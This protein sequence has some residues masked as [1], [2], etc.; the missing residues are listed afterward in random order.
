MNRM[1]FYGICFFIAMG[2]ASAQTA[3]RPSNKDVKRIIE[4][5]EKERARFQDALD[6]QLKNG[7]F[8]NANGEIHVMQYL[9]DF[10]KNIKTLKER[11]TNSYSASS[12]VKTVLVQAGYIDELVQNHPGAGG[13]S[14]WAHFSVELR[15]LAAAY[16]ASFPLPEGVV[17]RRYIDAEVSSTAD[18]V[19]K[20]ADDLKKE[21]EINATLSREAKDSYKRELDLLI[22]QAN[23][24]KWRTFHSDPAASEARK[25]LEQARRI[26][27]SLP[28]ENTS[29]AITASWNQMEPSLEI[30]A[31]AFG[32]PVP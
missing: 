21:I 31:A 3:E 25:L 7:V 24:V 32:M 5:L 29:G 15:A 12:E 11:Y 17:V 19:A 16:G 13:G 14:E 8:H 2:F 18:T 9:E 26:H 22:K 28:K 6:E 20:K 30:I 10:Q 1:F 27:Q 23:S 4:N